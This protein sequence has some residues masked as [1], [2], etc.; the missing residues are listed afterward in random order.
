LGLQWLP[1]VAHF[2]AAWSAR[3]QPQGAGKP[4]VVRA[5]RQAP[6]LSATKFAWAAS[7]I[8]EKELVDLTAAVIAI[9]AWNPA[10][11]A[12]RATPHKIAA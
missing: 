1:E 4:P 9:N 7:D 2:I 6:N 3:G 10:A 5:A 12:F 8:S 11:I